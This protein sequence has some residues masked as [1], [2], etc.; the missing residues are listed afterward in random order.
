MSKILR[1][2]KT[3]LKNFTED[4]TKVPNI[5]LH[6]EGLSPVDKLILIELQSYSTRPNY[7]LAYSRM[8]DKLKL[9]KSNFL[10]RWRQLVERGII[11]DGVTYSINYSMVGGSN[12]PKDEVVLNH[13]PTEQGGSKLPDSGGFNPPTK[14]VS[15]YPMSKNKEE[16]EIKNKEE[17][18]KR[19][20]S[21]PNANLIDTVERFNQTFSEKTKAVLR[22]KSKLDF[23]F[24][25]KPFLQKNIQTECYESLHKNVSQSTFKSSQNNVD[26]TGSKTIAQSK[27]L[28][29]IEIKDKSQSINLKQ[30]EQSIRLNDGNSCEPSGSPS[31]INEGVGRPGGGDELRAPANDVLLSNVGRVV[32]N[33]LERGYRFKSRIPTAVLIEGLTTQSTDD[34]ITKHIIERSKEIE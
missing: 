20:I 31:I 1:G 11:I 25:T 4:F 14:V 17:E 16:E 32:R 22:S 9:D 8:A 7:V 3:S 18:A 15:D 27:E 5:I 10:K 24:M 33:M 29:S 12:P 30:E 6:A 21:S 19:E 13:Q 26:S 23:L 34:E 2:K 28:N